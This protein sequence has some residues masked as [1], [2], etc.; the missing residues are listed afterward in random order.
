MKVLI[1]SLLALM[2]VLP[3]SHAF[4]APKE[5]K[6][7]TVDFSTRRVP[8]D[9]RVGTKKWKIE[10]GELRGEGSGALE[11]KKTMKGD[12][13]LSFDA[14]IE[15]KANVESDRL[16]PAWK[17]LHRE[18]GYCAESGPPSGGGG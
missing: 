16:R 13:T 4:N 9:W 2:V 10:Q 14:W 11:Y 18:T 5:K 7:V 17:G 8:P 6:I 12:F 3:F 15:E 1:P